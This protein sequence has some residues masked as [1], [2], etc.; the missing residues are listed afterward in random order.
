MRRRPSTFHQNPAAVNKAVNALPTAL[1]D[2]E[3]QSI[4]AAVSFADT[5]GQGSR[6]HDR[7][8][9]RPLRVPDPLTQEPA[10]E[11]ARQGKEHQECD[12]ATHAAIVRRV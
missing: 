8:P 5:R 6:G 2:P 11:H 1:D 7:D 10:R 4:A 3:S 12:D 9:P